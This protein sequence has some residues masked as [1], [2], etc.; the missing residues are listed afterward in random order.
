[1]EG[2]IIN[3]KEVDDRLLKEIVERI[4]SVVEPLKIIL[5]GSWAYGRPRSGSDIDILVVVEKSDVPRYKRAVPIYQALAGIFIPKDILV[6][7]VEE[8]KE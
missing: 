3:V 5:F 8:I 7:T 1:M 4:L 2:K 6:Y